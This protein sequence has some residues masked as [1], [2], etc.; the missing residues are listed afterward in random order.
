MNMAQKV[1]ANK[2]KILAT[3]VWSVEKK[4]ALTKASRENTVESFGRPAEKLG[5]CS[6]YR[7]PVK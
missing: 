4:V 2:I 1:D 3:A 6:R 5:V 7:N